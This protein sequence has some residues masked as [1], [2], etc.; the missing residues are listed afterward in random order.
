ML[1]KT[2]HIIPKSLTQTLMVSETIK[3]QNLIPIFHP[4]LLEQYFQ[5]GVLLLEFHPSIY[6]GSHYLVLIQCPEVSHEHDVFRFLE[7]LSMIEVVDYE[8]V[9]VIHICHCFCG[10]ALYGGDNKSNIGNKQSKS[11]RNLLRKFRRSYRQMI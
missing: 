5:P 10:F 9:E 1:Q 6:H 8:L 2:I 4:I 11:F 3:N 7:F